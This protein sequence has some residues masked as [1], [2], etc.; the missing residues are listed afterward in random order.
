MRVYVC[1]INEN[2]LGSTG[3]LSI[4][5]YLPWHT[6]TKLLRKD[7]ISCVLW[8]QQKQCNN[9][10]D[11]RT[12]QDEATLAPLNLEYWNYIWYWILEK[13]ATFGKTIFLLNVKQREVGCMSSVF[14]FRFMVRS[15]EPLELG[16]WNLVSRLIMTVPTDS[17]W[18]TV[19]KSATKNMTALRNFEIMLGKYNID[20]IHMWVMSAFQKETPHEEV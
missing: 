1:K 9:M 19:H 17:V 18:K 8:V 14:G 16:M 5:S 12:C 15:K 13:Y 6:S 7:N 2:Y 4:R 10:A 3:P 20:R 11:T